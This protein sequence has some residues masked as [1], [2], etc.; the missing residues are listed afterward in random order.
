MF[1][2]IVKPT[3][4]LIKTSLAVIQIYPV[5]Y[6]PLGTVVYIALQDMQTF[7]NQAKIMLPF[8]VMLLLHTC[9]T[10]IG[11]P[12]SSGAFGGFW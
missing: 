9:L 11:H 7:K 1:F 4:M 3:N 8:L 5:S 12:M 2:S 10:L 6:F